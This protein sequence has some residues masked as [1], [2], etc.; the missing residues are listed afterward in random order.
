[1]PTGWNGTATLPI[2]SNIAP[3]Y[4][5]GAYQFRFKE[6]G[7][8]GLI[9]E[10]GVGKGDPRYYLFRSFRRWPKLWVLAWM[11]I[12]EPSGWSEIWI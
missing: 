8:D 3:S 6:E 10:V 7:K 9:V 11:A 2:K 1:M 12:M 5:M 4:L